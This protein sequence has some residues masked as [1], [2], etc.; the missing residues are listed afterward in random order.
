[1]PFINGLLKKKGVGQLVNYCYLRFGLETTVTHAGRDQAARVPATPPGRPVDRHRRHGHPEPAR[2]T[3]V[4][5]A[6]EAGGRRAAAVPGRRH[7]QRRALQQGHRN[8]V[9]DHREGGRRDVQRHAEAATRKANFNPIYIMADSG[10]RGS[11]QQ[12]RQLAGMRGLMAKPSGE[13]IETPDHR[14]LPRRPD[15]AAVLHLHPRRAQ[16]PG[17]HGAEDRRL[18]LPDPPP[19]GRGAGRDHQRVRL[20]HRRRHLRRLHRR[21]AARSSSR[22][23]TASWAACRWRRSRTTKAT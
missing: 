14:Q 19:G 15:G 12:I 10:A 13:I 3:L 1:M 5:D 8:L 7:H 17:R 21:I 18:R 9:D 16:G 2:P 20:R 6:A 4:R 22:C 11:K 23:A